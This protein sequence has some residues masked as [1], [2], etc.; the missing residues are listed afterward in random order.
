MKRT[1]LVT[2]SLL[3]A[4]GFMY[5]LTG[6]WSIVTQ[7][8]STFHALV[9]GKKSS[10]DAQKENTGLLMFR[11]NAT[12]TFYGNGP[13]SAKPSFLWKYPQKPM[14]GPSTVGGITKLW[15][16][17]GWTGQPVVWERPDGV[18]EVIFGAYDHAVHFVDA[19]TGKETRSPFQT[20]DIIKGSV[21]LD[22][23]GYPLLYFGSRD[24][25]LRIIALDRTVPTELWKLEA[26]VSDGLWNNDWDSNPVIVDGMLYEG[27]EN[28]IFHA[29]ELNRS[30][31]ELGKV[32]VSPIERFSMKSYDAELLKNIGDVDVSIENSVL[33]VKDRAYFANSGGRIIGLDISNIKKGI[34]PIVFDFWAG[35]DI[36]ATLVADAEGMLYAGV[37]EERLNTRSYEVG[38]LL[39]LDPY[40]KN[41]PLVWSVSV[42]KENG[43]TGGIWATP[44]LV[45]NYLYVSTSPGHLLTVDTKTGVVLNRQYIGTHAWSSPAVIDHTLVVGTCTPGGINFYSLENPS[46]PQLTS[47]FNVPTEGC[48]E[49]TPAVWN[50]QLFFG[51]RDGFFY[52]L[53]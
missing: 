45:G 24:N 28:G 7:S 9:D 18:T 52:S 40:A 42:P 39:K 41:N 25:F 31:D 6:P 43:V 37:E 10:Q 2:F 44:A 4:V 5:Q 33:I 50:G 20:R 36:D 26:K 14:C 11:G 27:S 12:R 29:I 38:Q 48:V 46:T 35:D 47:R 49:S 8:A 30:Y 16:G 3:F 15:C 19:K 21:T 34:A 51:S 13:L 17:N 53:Q 32:I 1:I 22:P 23:D